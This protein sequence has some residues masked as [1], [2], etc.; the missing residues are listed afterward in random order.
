[1]PRKVAVNLTDAIVR[2]TPIPEGKARAYL[3]DSAVPGYF[4]RLHSDGR[5]RHGVRFRDARRRQRW[6]MIPGGHWPAL[7]VTKGREAARLML[8]G[9]PAGQDPAEARDKARA[10]D[11]VAEAWVEY[12]K[13]QEARWRPSTTKWKSWVWGQV[14]VERF[15]RL[16]LDAVTHAAVGRMHRDLADRPT[17]A[18]HGVLVLKALF[19]WLI[20]EEILPGPNPCA[21]VKPYK[22]APRERFLTMHETRILLQAI[23]QE[24]E[25]GGVAAVEREGESGGRG[26]AGMVERESRGISPAA[27]T[28]FRLLLLTGCRKSEIQLAKWSWVDW[29]RARLMLPEASSKTGARAAVLSAAALEE[30]KRAWDRRSSDW[31]VEGRVAGQ[32]LV[33]AAK[34]WARVLARANRL[35]HGEDSGSF[36]GLRIHDLRHSWVSA[37][38]ESGVPL[39]VAGRAVGHKQSRTSERYAHLADDPIAAAH[40]A[41][42]ARIAAAVAGQGAKVQEVRPAVQESSR[43]REESSE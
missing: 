6:I 25:L 9:L 41:V 20:A 32:P 23:S 42:A 18:N 12:C 28:L 10:G 5:G 16:Q 17:L 22:A 36:D 37:A 39:L 14:L 30:L 19:G 21:R 8:N 2:K 26:G 29:E 1:M 34:P 38:V 33:N 24:E 7:T 43:K 4:I 35:A 11:T 27:A 15:G 3:W 13:A 40:E 31:I